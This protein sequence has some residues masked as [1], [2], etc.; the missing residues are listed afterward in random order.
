MVIELA[1][2]N[3][4]IVLRSLVELLESAG[5]FFYKYFLLGFSFK[6]YISVS[7]LELALISDF[8][9]IIGDVIA[10]KEED[11]IEVS[12]CTL[13]IVSSKK[14]ALSVCELLEGFG[15]K[16]SLLVE[17]EGILAIRVESLPFIV[18]NSLTLISG[19][20]VEIR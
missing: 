13:I 5:I 16:G 12:F 8:L 4:M 2:K 9:T 6:F 15:M 17:A 1:I 20:R 14:E 10:I 7:P 3:E 19:V 11:E 18:K